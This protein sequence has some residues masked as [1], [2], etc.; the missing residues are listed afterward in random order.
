MEIISVIKAAGGN[1]TRNRKR[2]RKS[3]MLEKIKW[4]GHASFKIKAKDRLLYIDPWEIKK[5]EPA[6]LVFITHSHFDHLSSKDL[7]KLVTKDTYVIAP[8][9]CKT[10]IPGECSFMP[11]V[12]DDSNEI[13]DLKFKA[14]S[15]YNINKQF[16]PKSNNWLGYVI[17]I[18][19][20]KIYHCGDTDLIP[21]M[22][23]LEVDIALLAIGG[24][25]TMNAKEAAESAK[26]IKAKIVI[27]MHYGKIIGSDKDVKILKD[28]LPENIEL[29][30]LPVSE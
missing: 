30:I 28:N 5:P 4:L 10:D 21:E 27:P 18:E 6:D 16:H 22:N 20:N 25:Y 24:T 8:S 26:R 13:Y 15:A 17:E 23:A 9:D 3:K 19:G 12:P 14:V 11:V 7:K 2:R 1:S 29:K